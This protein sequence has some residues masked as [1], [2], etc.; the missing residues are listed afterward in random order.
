ML[1]QQPVK[2]LYHLYITGFTLFLSFRLGDWKL[3]RHNILWFFTSINRM[4]FSSY[5]KIGLV[6]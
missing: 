5:H 2:T 1:S 6:T 3:P 4:I